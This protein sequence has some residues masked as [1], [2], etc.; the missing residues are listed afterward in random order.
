MLMSSFIILCLKKVTCKGPAGR[1]K[2]KQIHTLHRLDTW[3]LSYTL[4]ST[5]TRRDTLS[6]ATTVAP[7]CDAAC[8]PCPAQP[9]HPDSLLNT[10]LRLQRYHLC[11]TQRNTSHYNSAKSSL[12]QPG[13]T[14]CNQVL[15]VQGKWYKDFSC[16]LLLI[17]PPFDTTNDFII[18]LCC[19]V[20]QY[21]TYMFN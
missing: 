21:I 16:S 8:A 1:E 6:V 13:A 10:I 20:N 15:K 5:C 18:K 17:F 9:P 12:A 14:W 7:P 3:P 19:W 4:Y 11:N 2:S